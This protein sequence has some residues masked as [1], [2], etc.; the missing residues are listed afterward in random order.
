MKVKVYYIFSEIKALKVSKLIC[1]VSRLVAN[2]LGAKKYNS[3]S[4]YPGKI[5]SGGDL[6][7]S[8]FLINFH[9]RAVLLFYIYF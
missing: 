8:F 3:T 7:F 1:M 6:R 4:Y 5:F 2:E 9:V